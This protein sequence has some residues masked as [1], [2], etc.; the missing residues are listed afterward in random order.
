MMRLLCQMTLLAVCLLLLT[1]T[2]A[3][4]ERILEYRSDIHVHEDGQL[5]I[6]ERIRVRAEGKNIKRGIYRDFPTRYRDRAGNYV[7]VEFS[8]LSVHRNGNA[9]S[10]H[11]REN[12]KRS[13]G[14][15]R[16]CQPHARPTHP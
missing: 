1:V 10:W 7:N 11:T 16:Q 12:V 13:P 8:P 5:T 15:C 14:L 6:T 4:D 9:E 3:A 2:A